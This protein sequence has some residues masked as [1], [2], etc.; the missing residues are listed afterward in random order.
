[1]LQ[2]NTENVFFGRSSIEQAEWIVVLK[3]WHDKL[4]SC[5]MVEYCNVSYICHFLRY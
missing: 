3:D 4:L 2:S 1:M 5:F